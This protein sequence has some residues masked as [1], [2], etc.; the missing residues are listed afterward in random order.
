MKYTV[1]QGRLHHQWC[2]YEIKHCIHSLCCIFWLTK[3][4]IY[5]IL[6]SLNLRY[7][8]SLFSFI[9]IF[10]DIVSTS[11]V[12]RISHNGGL[13]GIW[14][15]SGGLGANPPAAG[16][17]GFRSKTLGNFCNFSI[18]KTHFYAYFGKNSYFYSITQPLKTFKISLNVLNWINE[19]QVL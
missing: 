1:L 3:F 18:K 4:G 12:A 13:A 19:V 10:I 15:P 7:Q 17:W 9:F 5:L 8:K 16:G 2:P 14:R 6:R 11:G